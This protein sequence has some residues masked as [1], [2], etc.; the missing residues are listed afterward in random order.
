MLDQRECE[1]GPLGRATTRE[2]STPCKRFA[3]ERRGAMA[4]VVGPSGV[5]GR[6]LFAAAPFKYTRPLSER[7]CNEAE[8]VVEAARGQA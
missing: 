8:V 2:P 3:R 5:R 7:K 1:P 6:P 4:Q